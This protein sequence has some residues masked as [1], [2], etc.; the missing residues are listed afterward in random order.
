MAR[1][2]QVPSVRRLA[3]AAAFVLVGPAVALAADPAL[4][5]SA[6]PALFSSSPDPFTDV[7]GSRCALAG[8]SRQNRPELVPPGEPGL[9]GTIVPP[10]TRFTSMGALSAPAATAP[11]DLALVDAFAAPAPP[12]S[13]A[14]L[15]ALAPPAAPPAPK[16]RVWFG[17]YGGVLN[18]GA[19]HEVLFMPWQTSFKPSYLAAA[20]LTYVIHEF[21]A[22]PLSVELDA[23][24]AKRFGPDD[25]WDFGVVPMFRW[26]SF[27]WNDY[28]YTNLRAGPFG[29]SYTTGISNFERFNSGNRKGSQFLNFLVP[30]LTFSSGPDANWEAFIR[31]HHRSGIYGLINGVYGGSNYVS[32]GYRW[33]N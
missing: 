25:E 7:C 22:L 10:P 28:L 18:P 20:N 30:E 21:S 3:A 26:K 19:L 15:E 24:V 6:G 17:V 2:G 8:S 14:S 32:L 13:F 5:S 12:Q 1:V 16:G 11:P 27:P 29:A 9:K 33:R 4:P 23:V 31:V